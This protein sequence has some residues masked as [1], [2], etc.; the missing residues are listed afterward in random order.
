MELYPGSSDQEVGGVMSRLERVLGESLVQWNDHFQ[1]TSVPIICYNQ[2]Y[3][4]Y[5]GSQH[6]VK[7]FIPLLALAFSYL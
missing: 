7:Q 1:A 6:H 3:S 2:E 4:K 5:T